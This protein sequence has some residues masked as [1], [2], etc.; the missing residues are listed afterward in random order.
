MN[1]A[2]PRLFL[3]LLYFS[4][5]PFTCT[6]ESYNLCPFPG[7][8]SSYIYVWI[9]IVFHS[10]NGVYLVFL[11]LVYS[12]LSPL[13]LYLCWGN[14]CKF[15]MVLNFCLQYITW[16]GKVSQ[17]KILWH[18]PKM[19][20]SSICLWNSCNMLNIVAGSFSSFVQCTCTIFDYRH[21]FFLLQ[22]ATIG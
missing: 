12:L 20:P 16:H 14:I 18:L 13:C 8:Q 3:K 1:V 19:M 21:W 6:K 7:L 2:L 10:L 5:K 17:Q 22:G 11:T 4:F 15:H 9:W